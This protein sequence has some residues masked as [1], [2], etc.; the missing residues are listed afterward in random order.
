M[1]DIL[2]IAMAI[3][4]LCFAALGVLPNRNQREEHTQSNHASSLGQL[5]LSNRAFR[6]GYVMLAD[7]SRVVINGEWP[8]KNATRPNHCFRRHIFNWIP[9]D[10]VS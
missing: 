8:E 9:S 10:C 3:S 6:H 5:H 2:A 7:Y 4:I 1:F